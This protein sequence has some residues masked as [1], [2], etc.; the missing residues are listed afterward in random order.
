MG[1]RDLPTVRGFLR[2]PDGSAKPMEE[3]TPEELDKWDRERVHRTSRVMSEIFS[4]YPEAASLLEEVS[5]ERKKAFYER[6]PEF[7]KTTA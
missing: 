7:K 3:L 2:M 1:R 5:P 6:F 4:A